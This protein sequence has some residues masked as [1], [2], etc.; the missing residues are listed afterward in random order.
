MNKQLANITLQF[1]QRVQLSGNEVPAYNA[2]VQSLQDILNSPEE[3][4]VPVSEE[5]KE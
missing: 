4:E 2:V 1:L 3:V 5:F